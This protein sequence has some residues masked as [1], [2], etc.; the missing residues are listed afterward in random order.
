LS[1]KVAFDLRIR[2]PPGFPRRFVGMFRFGSSLLKHLGNIL[3]SSDMT[4]YVLYRRDTQE[5][6]VEI[7][8]NMPKSQIE[9]VGVPND[10]D[11]ISNSSWLQDWFKH[12]KINLYY[13]IYYHY[14]IRYVMN[15]QYPIPF[16]HT[17]HD[18]IPIKHPDL[19]YTDA[20]YQKKYGATEFNH[21]QRFLERFNSYIPLN[22]TPKPE[23]EIIGKY[24][25]AMNYYLAKQSKQI[26]T[27]SEAVKKDIERYLSVNSSKITVIHGAVDI[28]YCLCIG[29]QNGR[30]RLAWLF[31]ALSRC[32][33]KLPQDSKIVIVGE[34]DSLPQLHNLIISYALEA[35]VMFIGTVSDDDLA[36]LYSSAKAVVISTID[37]GFCLPAVEALACGT[38]VIVPNTRVLREIL[39]ESGHYYDATN[40]N[41]LS[42][43]LVQ[44]FKDSL[45]PKSIYF[46]NRFNW[47][48]SAQNLFELL[49]SI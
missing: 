44:A 8:R 7:L 3:L 11:L 18:L 34:Y 41:Q 1:K 23:N 15:T 10:V 27:V 40:I 16:V 25:W 43:L 36:C 14:L 46:Y 48:Q 45:A 39:G 17:V 19:F 29:M 33:D 4:L 24:T 20:A 42:F 12:K 6:Q 9:Y 21:V 38:E 5:Q 13:A 37:E 47:E 26:V 49:S 2:N 28:R 30:K 35:L 32:Q 31:E 22:Y